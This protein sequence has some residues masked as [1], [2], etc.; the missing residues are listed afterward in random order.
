MQT[1]FSRT[2]IGRIVGRLTALCVV[3]TLLACNMDDEW[4]MRERNLLKLQVGVA[5]E[6]DVTRIMG[7]ASDE[8]PE[9]G[10]GKVLSYPMGP[11]G[12]HTWMVTISPSGTVTAITQV[13]TEE[14]F[15]TVATGMS[16]QEIRR[17]LG[18]PRSVVE[19]KRKGEEVWDWKYRNVYEER[20][21]NVHFDI[22]T[23]RVARTSYS[24]IFT[25]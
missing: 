12:I 21:F 20:M 6:A 25:R 8:W 16:R 10:Q 18:K 11:Q 4:M 7:V 3:A 22:D 1:V 19:F 9:A 2:V 17:L 14:N 13:L 23:G 24:E 15:E 5:T